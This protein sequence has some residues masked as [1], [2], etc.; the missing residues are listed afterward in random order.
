MKLSHISALLK[1]DLLIEW[2]MRSAFQGMLLYVICTIFVCYLSFKL[3]SG[4][5]SVPTWNALFWIILLFVATTAISKS[6]HQESSQRELYYRFLCLPEEIIIS[7]I[8]YNALIVTFLALL[9]IF[10]YSLVLGN[11]V[12]DMGLFVLNLVL[13]ATG[14]SST[15]TMVSGITQ[16]AGN[17]T[18]LMAILSFPIILPLLLMLIKVSRNAID[19][20]TWNDS[21]DELLILGA[22]NGIVLACSYILFPYLWRS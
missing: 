1:K 6:F 9:C 3:R 8:I 15:L 17:N 16:K 21:Q 10:F 13:G 2:R 5:V 14:F 12:Q 20:L 18:T 11:P 19:G 7:K 4:Q 22:L